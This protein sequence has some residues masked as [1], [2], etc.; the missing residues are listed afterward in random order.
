MGEEDRDGERREEGDSGTTALFSFYR[1]HLPPRPLQIIGHAH[2]GA[3]GERSTVEEIS[4]SYKACTLTLLH[5]VS[6]LPD[7]LVMM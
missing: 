5:Q 1:R 2:A 4:F 7:V 3:R 6:L